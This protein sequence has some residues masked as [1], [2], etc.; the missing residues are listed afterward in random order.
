MRTVWLMVAAAPVVLF[1]LSSCATIQEER[2]LKSEVID[3]KWEK[4][5]LPD[6]RSVA[7]KCDA[8]DTQE[9]GCQLGLRK[10]CENKRI[11][12][13]SQTQVVTRTG[14]VGWQIFEYL[15]GAAG[16]GAG[17]GVVIDAPNVPDSNDPKQTNPIGRTGA[18]VIGVGL[19]AA[20]TSLAIL[21]VVDSV[22]ARDSEEPAG[23]IRQEGESSTQETCFTGPFSQGN[24][25][26][27]K[28]STSGNLPILKEIKRWSSDKGFIA[29]SSASIKTDFCPDDEYATYLLVAE[30][31]ELN[32]TALV[33]PL[34]A[35]A[36]RQ[37][38]EAAEAEKAVEAQRLFEVQFEETKGFLREKN[39]SIVLNRLEVMARLPLKEEQRDRLKQ[40]A[41]DTF[42]PLLNDIQ[43]LIV[44][45][46][47]PGAEDLLNSMGNFSLPTG[48]QQKVDKLKVLVGKKRPV[49]ERQEAKK[50][51]REAKEEARRQEKAEAEAQRES[52][53]S[54]V[55]QS[56][57]G[58]TYEGATYGID[59]KDVDV[60]GNKLVATYEVSSFVATLFSG[61]MASAGWE[62]LELL[63]SQK[64]QDLAL[65]NRWLSAIEVRLVTTFARTDKFGN[66]VGEVKRLLATAATSGNTLRK[67]NL[68]R[69]SEIMNYKSV[70]AMFSW[71]RGF[72]TTYSVTP[73]YQ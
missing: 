58:M 21:G 31:S 59:L 35:D 57:V 73:G 62:V 8:Q 19:I 39:W 65:E 54:R 50:Q 38:R 47:I 68:D 32:V 30:K 7:M 53:K 16:I 41:S 49:Y 69:A 22:R 44:K 29:F 20:G 28:T 71:L 26:L 4:V 27:R 40:L 12:L 11:D 3:T 70:A 25:V 36:N 18:Y 45:L 9:I 15:S 60:V 14:S 55:Q 17:T 24:V 6:K 42:D 51:E 56:T 37:A 43:K 1:S 66:E 5:E 64:M 48:M 67:I 72:V 2:T 33:H 23:Q 10:I 52:I 34:C 61:Q 46:D 63:F 13:V